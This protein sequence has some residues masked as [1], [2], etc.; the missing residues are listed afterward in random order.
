MIVRRRRLETDIARGEVEIDQR[1][2]ASEVR[3]TPPSRSAELQVAV[4]DQSVSAALLYLIASVGFLAAEVVVAHSVVADAFRA[5]YGIRLNE[6]YGCTECSPVISV[7]VATACSRS[8]R[9]VGPSSAV[10]RSWIQP[11]TA[12]S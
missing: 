5:R 2:A 11:W 10:F 9:S 4:R 12:I 3:G 7:R 6:G 8:R 1:Q